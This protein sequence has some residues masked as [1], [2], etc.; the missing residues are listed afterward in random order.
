MPS[1]SAKLEKQASTEAAE[2]IKQGI[3][4][5]EHK[6]R[7]LEKRKSRLEMY[8]DQQSHG[9]ELNCDQLAAI[10]K[11]DEVLQTLEFARELYKQFNGIANETAKQQ[12]KQ[13]RKDALEKAQQEL[14]KLKEILIIQDVLTNMGQD[15]VREDF[16]AGRNGAVK[17]TEEDL[18]H[19][20][21]LFTEV[22]PKREL[23]DGLPPFPE[24][25]QKA[26]EH[27]IFLAEG[28]NKEV[29][30]TTYAN[31]R[32]KIQEIHTCGYFDSSSPPTVVPD[33][34]A[35]VPTVVP[36]EEEDVE[37]D[38]EE[39]ESVPTTT[40]QLSKAMV[41][42]PVINE[43]VEQTSTVV[44]P[45]Q[46]P[47]SEVISSVLS[48]ANSS[49]Q[50]LQDSELDS[51]D[52]V[53]P[54]AP[55][56]SALPIPTQTFTNQNFVPPQ[57]YPQQQPPPQ[58]QPVY[59]AMP[60][61]G[62]QAPYTPF[63]SQPPPPQ[64]QPA[65]FQPQ[66]QPPAQAQPQQQQ[67][68]QPPAQVERLTDWNDASSGAVIDSSDWN[69]QCDA[70]AAAAAAAAASA[71]DNAWQQQQ[72]QPQQKHQQSDSW[73][74]EMHLVNNDGFMPAGGRGG[75]GGRGNR[76]S[77]GVLR[78]LRGGGRNPSGGGF[79]RNNA[80]DN[81]GGG[82]YYQSNGFQ[83][84]NTTGDHKR[85]GAGGPRVGAGGPRSD[86]GSRGGANRGG[87]GGNRQ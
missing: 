28:K 37:A 62:Q 43:S 56:A 84:R 39:P 58:P 60:I 12:K 47:V 74:N 16:L 22:S 48:V 26:A 75:G 81:T 76:G 29:I 52:V 11:Y 40:F 54:T 66:A 2:P 34:V 71:S 79:Y 4:I 35:E 86:R 20:D 23:E 55:P 85:G 9:K 8:R 5:I 57:S 17:L 64:P 59:T 65:T 13:A 38:E 3:T 72:Q 45:P 24:Q 63:T 27:L 32:Q 19:L 53:P 1:A 78:A 69:A 80:G 31:L 10:A 68:Q 49:F 67:Q 83:N 77:R 61:S 44:I 82:N 41:P 25:I 33:S 36:A 15:T 6:I 7:N 51:P 30:G 73:A 46:P 21:N 50:F 42:P 18:Q 14:A 70:A 87:R